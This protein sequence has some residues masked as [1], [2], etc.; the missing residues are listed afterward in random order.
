M[1]TFKYSITGCIIFLLVWSSCVPVQSDLETIRKQVMDDLMQREVNTDRVESIMNSIHDDGTWPGIDYV[2]VSNEGFQHAQHLSNLQMLSHAFMKEGSGFRGNPQLKKVIDSGLDYWLE[3]DFICENWWW[4]QIGTPDR[5]VNIY[6]ILDEEIS[7]MQNEG[8]Q[9]VFDRSTMDAWGARPGGDRIKIAEIYGKYAL[10]KR[11]E[12]IFS[13]VIDVMAAEIKISEKRGLQADMSFHHRGDRVNNTLSYGTQY[14]DVFAEWAVLVGDTRYTFPDA[15]L[16]MLIDF[17]LDGICQMMVHGKFSDPGAKNRGITRLGALRPWSSTT[18][19]NLLKT[20]TYRSTE[21]EN[22]IKIRDDD[23][24]SELSK[25]RFFWHSEYYSHQRPG[26]FTSVRMFSTRNKS[27]EEPY[28]SEGLKNHHL[29]DGSNFISVTGKEYNN[30]WPVY[31]WQRIPGSTVVQKKEL[32][33]PEK[34]QQPGSMDFAGGV[35]DDKYGAVA[36]DFISPLDP[37]TARKAWFMFDDEI[38]CL[39]AGI[40][41]DAE[42]PVNTTLNQCYLTGDV[43][44]S[45][46]KKV[47]TLEKGIHDLKDISWISHENIAYVFPDKSDIHIMNDVA[48]G[49]WWDIHKGSRTSRDIIQKDVFKLWLDHGINPK[50]SEYEYLIVPGI[51]VSEIEEYINKSSI[52]IL[53]NSTMIQAVLHV[54]LEMLQVVFYEPGEITYGDSFTFTMKSAGLLMVHFQNNKIEKITISDPT[55]KLKTMELGINTEITLDTDIAVIH[56]DENANKTLIAIELPVDLYAGKSVVI[57]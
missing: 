33:D 1:K 57:Q 27:M 39:G 34:I 43:S 51:D 13:E 55:R 48:S 56:R 6:L 7:D 15:A 9:P 3:N 18:P 12:D 16:E 47:K 32:P 52:E 11:D 21:L 46:D 49:S 30:I 28:N 40:S 5:M 42:L 35:T 8:A 41:S 37:L 23:I 54:G 38:V 10:L 26:Y 14:A 36:F 53:V 45:G 31:D 50:D 19:E 24:G 22:I 2:D 44:T 20:T 29:G 17:Y 4:N 25:D